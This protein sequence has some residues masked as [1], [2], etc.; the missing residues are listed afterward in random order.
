MWIGELARCTGVPVRTIRFYER[1]GVLRAP[2]R[3]AAGYRLYT[4]DELDRLAFV[5]AC[6]AIGFTL[7]E[8]AELLA[9]R[10]GVQSPCPQLIELVERRVEDMD[11]RIG[12]MTEARR[13][14]ARLAVQAR[15]LAPAECPPTTVDALIFG[16]D[17]G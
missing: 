11:A 6:K 2:A 7:E 10:D 1:I 16:Q 9:A 14:L 5:R 8:I 4:D 3:T 13:R 15:Q 12:E 17:G